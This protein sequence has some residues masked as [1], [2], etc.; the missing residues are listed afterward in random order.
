MDVCDTAIVHSCGESNDYRDC[1]LDIRRENVVFDLTALMDSPQLWDHF[2]RAEEYTPEFVDQ[3]RRF[4]SWMSRGPHPFE[5]VV[6]R[7][8]VERFGKPTWPN[9]HT[10]AICLTHDIDCIRYSVPKTGFETLVAARRGDFRS[11]LS[12]ALSRFSRS[13]N[14]LW[15]FDDIMA[16]EERYSA[17]SSF[18]FLALEPGEQ[19]YN[20]RIHEAGDALQEIERRGWEVGLHGGHE[21]WSDSSALRREK[22]RIEQVLGS[23]VVGYRNHY[24]RFAIPK[25]WHLLAEVGFV[26]DTTF[27]WADQIGFR[28]GMCHPYQPFDRNTEEFVNIVELPVVI[29]D[30]TFD[31]YLGVSDEKAFELTRVI[32]DR[33]AEVGGVATILW[34]NTDF[35][36]SRREL[37]ERILAYGRERNAW[38]PM[39]RDVVAY[40]REQTPGASAR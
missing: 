20:F 12:M 16:L 33:T 29:M 6:S 7:A 36:G 8:L 5:P 15:N 38:M 21:A 19:D 11:A 32:L 35:V 40:W 30:R 1:C 14:P 10:F 28:N 24:L 25:T 18:F 13:Q 9:G 34:H 2:S 27:G 39:A 26:Y 31:R 17:R 23:A 4:R 37:Y 22:D 3:Y